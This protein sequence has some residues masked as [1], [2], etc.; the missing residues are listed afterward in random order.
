MKKIIL[1]FSFALFSMALPIAMAQQALAQDGDSAAE[2]E[3]AISTD[4]QSTISDYVEE[5]G[6]KRIV[7]DISTDDPEEIEET[8]RKL[9][10][11]VDRLGGLLGEEFQRE[12]TVELENLSDEEKQ[13]LNAKFDDLFDNGIRISG[14]GVG[15]GEAIIAIVA[16]CMTFGLPLFIL[17]AVLVFA[18]RKRTQ[19]RDLVN[20]YIAADKPIPPHVLSE[21]GGGMS[22]D[23]RLRSGLIYTLVGAAFAVMLGILA[24]WDV[25]AIGLI[26]MAIGI[27]RLL[28]W[29]YE[30]T[31]PQDQIGEQ[32]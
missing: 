4:V 28:F 13:E 10:K 32:I 18:Q 6:K 24:D 30:T 19:M 21:F 31:K 23:K 15:G 3:V 17:I 11:V 20:A 12:L 16:I 22:G 9:L 8:Q 7:V 14:G 2:A 26:P 27:A 1:S 5:D 25:A 29:R